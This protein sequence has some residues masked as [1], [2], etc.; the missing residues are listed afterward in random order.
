[1][2]ENNETNSETTITEVWQPSVQLRYINKNIRIPYDKT[3]MKLYNETEKILQQLHIS[4]LGNRKWIDISIIIE[5][6]L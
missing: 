5:E 6:Q 4:N 3:L 2:K 1:M